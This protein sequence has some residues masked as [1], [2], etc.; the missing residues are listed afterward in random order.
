MKRAYPT[1]I[2][3]CGK[4]YLVY[5]PDMDIYTEGHDLM[6]AIEMARDA[7]GLKGIDLEDD[8]KGIPEASSYKA[9]SA[10]AKADADDF[11]YTQG[12]LTMVDVDF[13]EYRK[14]MENKMVR[15]N[16][17]LPNWLNLEADRLNLNVS[18]VLQEALADRV[19]QMK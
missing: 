13:S 16:V 18:K 15:R 9:A 2:A 5:V 19:A 11:D 17:T 1:F 8:G 3:E 14:R 7:I 6:D 4:D 10:K 12:M